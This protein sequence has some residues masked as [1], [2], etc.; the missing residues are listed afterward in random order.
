MRKEE[1]DIKK[2]DLCRKEDKAEV[3]KDREELV[4]DVKEL[5]KMAGDGK[6]AKEECDMEEED[7]IRE[8]T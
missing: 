6:M 7:E 4:E 8:T 1:E 2:M 3:D 5:K